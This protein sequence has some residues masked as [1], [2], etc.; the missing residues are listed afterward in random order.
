[1]LKVIY[2]NNEPY[3]CLLMQ[4]KYFNTSKTL[5]LFNDRNLQKH[6]PNKS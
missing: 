3:N 6:I 5:A 2:N 4:S 1:M